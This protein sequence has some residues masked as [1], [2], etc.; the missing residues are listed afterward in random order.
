MLSLM[1]IKLTQKVIIKSA[2][3]E[4]KDFKVELAVLKV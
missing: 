3:M 1:K 4:I 2:A